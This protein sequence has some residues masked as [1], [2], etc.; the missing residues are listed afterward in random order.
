MNRAAIVAAAKRAQAAYILDDAGARAAFEGLEQ[1]FLGRY[2]ND[3]HQAVV[4]QDVAGACYLSISGTRFGH[5][6][7]DLLEDL[8]IT[9]KDLGN[10]MR[11]AAGVYD[12]MQAMWDWAERLVPAGATWN[13]EGHSLGAERALL[14]GLFLPAAHVGAIHA[15]EAPRC[16]N[17][18]LWAHLMPTLANA[19]CVVDGADL[20]FGWP[21]ASEWLHVPLPHIWL[22]DD[23]GHA[24]LIMP[25]KWP[26]GDNP[27]DH[28]IARVV[29]RLIAWSALPT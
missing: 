27:D 21:Q 6:L 3:S 1:T 28:D 10:G 22:L 19:G 13:V 20:W 11:V 5:D 24:D 14:A 8:H 23:A 25:D 17:A 2:E 9:G 29:E 12:G 18:A 7:G 4:S 15:F 26:E 16:G